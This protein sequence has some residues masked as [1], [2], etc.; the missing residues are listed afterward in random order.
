LSGS[1][2]D[3]ITI[4]G[5]LLLDVTS[6]SFNE[7]QALI[8]SNSLTELVAVVP[9]EATSGKI[10]VTTAQGETQSETDFEVVSTAPLI[11]SFTPT[12]AKAGEMVTITG[13]NLTDAVEVMINEVSATIASNT[14]T[15]IEF[16]V[17]VHAT[18]GKISVATSQGLAVSST[19]FTFIESPT[20]SSISPISGFYGDNITIEGTN[21]SGIKE[22]F[23]GFQ[24]ATI[25]ATTETSVEFTI[26]E[27][28]KIGINGLTI[29]DGN[30]TVE[31]GDLKFYVIKN[32]PDLIQTF[33][34]A[35]VGAYVGTKDPEETTFF[36]QSNELASSGARHLPPAIEG[37]YFHMEGFCSSQIAGTFIHQFFTNAQETGFYSSFIGDITAEDLFVNIQVNLG[38]LPEGYG[39]ND[40][41]Y[42]L[43]LRLR[44]AEGNYGYVINMDELKAASFGPDENGWYNASFPV[45]LFLDEDALGTFNLGD[46]QR[47]GIVARRAYGTGGVTGVELDGSEGG[48]A[49]SFSFDNLFATVG[50]PYSFK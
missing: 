29:G 15:E 44:F 2:S 13:I 36:G 30:L 8:I 28:S 14:E 47:I 31:S 25:L 49:Y 43:G 35:Y 34:G 12:S 45:S 18:S 42:V 27:N 22:V 37:N 26:P 10:Q 11:T 4:Y 40:S 17:P 48:I 9:E 32:D 24:E 23:V 16:T 5:S 50:G 3:T 33:D 19:D 20:I 46:L 41:D 6:V 1:A 39:E 21:M 7:A 38:A